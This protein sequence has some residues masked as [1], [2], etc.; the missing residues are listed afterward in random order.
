MQDGRVVKETNHAGGI[1]GGISDGSDII[2]RAAVKPTP[3]I[4]QTQKTVN[5]AGEEIEITIGGRH[6]PVIVPRAVVVV[7]AM[8]ALT[9]ADALLVS[10]TSRLDGIR[11]FF[12]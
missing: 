10:M 7:E 11:R 5:R 3:S 12:S 1:L 9:L 2:L 6:D 8:T 4:A